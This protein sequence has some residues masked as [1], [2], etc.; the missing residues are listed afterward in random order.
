MARNIVGEK[1]WL[2][3]PVALYIARQAAW[4][5]LKERTVEIEG[6]PGIDLDELSIRTKMPNEVLRRQVL[7]GWEDVGANKLLAPQAIAR[8]LPK[9]QIKNMGW[10]KAKLEGMHILDEVLRLPSGPFMASE[11]DPKIPRLVLRYLQKIGLIVKIGRAPVKGTGAGMNVYKTTGNY[12]KFLEYLNSN[13]AVVKED[14]IG[15]QEADREGDQSDME[16]EE[17]MEGL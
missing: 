3:T 2:L 12:I 7:H 15:K 11:L 8:R 9:V 5:L 4:E 17:K 10:I 13:P 14:E 6:R 1:N 16:A